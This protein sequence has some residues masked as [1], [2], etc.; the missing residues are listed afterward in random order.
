MNRYG[1]DV[2]GGPVRLHVAKVKVPL[3]AVLAGWLAGKAATGVSWLVR[4]PLAL[5][6]AVVALGLLRALDV[7]GPLPIGTTMVLGLGCLVVWRVLWPESFRVQVSWRARGW[8][9]GRWPYRFAWQ[10]AMVTTGLAVTVDGREYLPKIRSV[11]STGTVD[12]LRV[13]MLPGQ[14]IE[15]WAQA[16]P[17]LAQ[18]FAAAECRVRTLLGKRQ[19][20]MLWFLVHDPLTEPVPPLEPGPDVD[21][22]AVPVGRREDGLV[23]RLR[24]LGTHVLVVGA[25]GSGKGSVIW[26]LIN[27]VASAVRDGRVEVWALDPKGGMELAG[28][29]ALFSRFVYGDP[30]D[31]ATTTDAYEQEFADVLED[32][33]AVMRRRQSTLRGVTRLHT[34]TPAEPLIVIVVDELASL[35]AYVNDRDA[36]R[37]IQA[38]LSLLLSQGRA[39]GVTVVGAV[40]DPR[41]EILAVRDLFPTRIALR[42]TEAEQVGL[43]LG[44]GARDRGAAC[45]RIPESLPGVGYVGID[46][47]AEPVRVRFSHVTDPDI[48]RLA[49][50]YAPGHVVHGHVEPEQ[51]GDRE[52]AEPNQPGEAA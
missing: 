25:T 48:D 37:R 13:R 45:D 34:P 30:D 3:S 35:T 33:V 38:A 43:V 16:G 4:H 17:R 27:G 11:K 23:Y 26:S 14:T 46:G 28:G 18:T 22:A 1:G 20:L 39:V 44:A 12:V 32:A 6:P 9:R 47:I 36:K 10:P 50:D 42:L 24:L 15:D 21:L 52:R 8:W 40:Q 31:V 51:A 2:H 41:K 5:L 29:R 19:E 49:R 7:L